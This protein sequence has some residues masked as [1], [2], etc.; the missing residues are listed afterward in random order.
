MSELKQ[1]HESIGV[2]EM[3]KR[4]SYHSSDDPE[5]QERYVILRA[6]AKTM[7]DRIDRLCPHS[8]EKS[9]AITKLEEAV[10]WANAS[11]ARNE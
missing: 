1:D 10:M 6:L 2:P 7:A 3:I 9:I 8:R 11:I 4:F 5:V